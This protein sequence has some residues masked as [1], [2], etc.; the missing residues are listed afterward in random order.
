M[1]S[2]INAYGF[3]CH[4]YNM[5]LGITMSVCGSVY[6]WMDY[7]EMK[8]QTFMVPMGNSTTLNAVPCV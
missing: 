5:A 4:S 2:Q 8:E 7:Y 6:Y 1:Y 3:I